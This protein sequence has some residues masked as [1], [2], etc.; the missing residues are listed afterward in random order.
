MQDQIKYR[1]FQGKA[2]G[3]EHFFALVAPAH[4]G[5]REQVA[6]L[7]T[8]YENAL[9]A[10]GLGAESAVFRRIFLSDILNQ[11]AVVAA[12][13]LVRGGE[14]VA[15]SVIQQPP[16]AGAKIALLAYHVA[17]PLVKRRVSPRDIVVERG[18]LRHVWS[19][20]YGG[21]ATAP[22]QTREVLGELGAW[23]AT[24]SGRLRDHC[25]RTWFY[26]KN[27][28]VFYQDFVEARRALFAEQGLTES[29][30]YLSSTG[31]EGASARQ[32]GIVTMDAY[33]VLG[34]AQAQMSFL[35]DFERLCPTKNYNVTFERG[36]RIAYADRAHLFISGTASI[37]KDG[38][39]VHAGEVL[40]QVD[41]TLTNIAALLRSGGAEM[42]DLMYLIVYLRDPSDYARVQALLNE[43]FPGLPLVIVQGAVCRPEWLVEIEGVAVTAHDDS[44]LPAF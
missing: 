40:L 16:L 25:V 21:E 27:I 18:A 5:F 35:N 15:V 8:A 37:D 43:R 34:L 30:H 41:H 38:A 2:G 20:G 19:V 10:Q 31:I 28:D 9:T 23:L 6:Y 4:L 42:R 33:S 3:A 14:P 26:L 11:N 22:A 12:S 7:E 1:S 36:T 39:V 32:H 29:T 17:G 24:Q 44:A 13:A